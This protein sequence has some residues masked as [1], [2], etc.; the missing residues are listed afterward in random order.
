M[1]R[2]KSRPVLLVKLLVRVKNEQDMSDFLSE[3][4][5]PAELT[6]ANQRLAVAKALLNGA[7]FRSI[8]SRHKISSYVINRTKKK[9][10]NAKSGLIKRLLKSL[11]KLDK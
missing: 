5:S 11:G 8:E 7:T 2:R 9:I 4:F 6:R 10:L 1:A 3:L